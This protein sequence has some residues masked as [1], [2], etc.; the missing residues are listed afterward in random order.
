[1][2]DEPLIFVEVALVEGM[3]DNV[4]NL[5]DPT[6][7]VHDPN[8]ADAAIFYSISNAQAGLSGISFGNFLIKRVVDRLSH[9][10]PKL[11][12][13]ATL[14]PIPGFM[15][16]LRTR[17][18]EG[19]SGLLLP[20]ERKA[21]A[22]TAGL[23]RGVKGWLKETL[24]RPDWVNDGAVV[25]ALKAPLMRLCA[26]YLAQEK[27]ARGM[28][29]DPVG[30]FHLSNGARMER[31]NWMADRSAKGLEQAAGMM[32]NYRYDLGRIDAN[33]EA[34]RSTGKPALSSAMKA[35]LKG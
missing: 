9:E 26:R 20:S 30:H 17:V 23:Q 2:P 5:L 16:W 6:A 1:M 13:F 19:D 10:F 11:K 32:I 14:S 21:L 31:L 29:L 27:R 25:K 35:L 34:Y 8:E 12:T 3:A 7:P 24:E 28:A 22:A 15:P 18:A 33:H 4:Q